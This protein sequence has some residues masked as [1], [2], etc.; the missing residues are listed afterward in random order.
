VFALSKEGVSKLVLG[1]VIIHTIYKGVV[2]YGF[3]YAIMKHKS[4]RQSGSGQTMSSVKA[5][6][7]GYKRFDLPP[8]KRPIK[9]VVE[10]PGH[11][12]LIRRNAM[13]HSARV[14]LLPS[15]M[16]VSSHQSGSGIRKHHRR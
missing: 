9:R 16:P 12:P 7:D 13:D 15:T 5:V 14:R 2:T 4:H 8:D 10:S 11:T 3:S 1:K 6:H